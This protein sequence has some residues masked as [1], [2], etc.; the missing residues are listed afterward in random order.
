MGH[1]YPNDIP[2][3][4]SCLREIGERIDSIE[5]G[6]RHAIARSTL[7]KVY[8]WGWNGHG[9][10]GHGHFDSEL[11]PRLLEL[12]KGTLKREKILQIGAGYSHTVVMTD[13]RELIQF[14]SSGTLHKQANPVPM[15]LSETLPNLFPPNSA[16]ANGLSGQQI[17]F[18][19]VKLNCSWSKS[20]S[21]TNLSI[22]D[23]RAINEDQS[24]GKINSVLKQLSAKWD[25]REV[26]PP[27]IDVISG[28]FPA[29][30]M[31]KPSNFDGGT[32]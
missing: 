11:S 5:C 22:V 29:S 8:S 31:R 12:S 26:M 4:V 9:Q 3:M 28:L 18:A 10:L 24:F 21:T 6:F 13:N 1:R 23:L 15:N 20:M 19:V 17:D 25:Q 7:G 2:E 16:V 32:A 14:G 30:L 27:Y